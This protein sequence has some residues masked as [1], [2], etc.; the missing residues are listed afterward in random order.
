MSLLSLILSP[1]NRLFI[2]AA[3]DTSIFLCP[4]NALAFCFDFRVW[5]KIVLNFFLSILESYAKFPPQISASLKTSNFDRC[6]A[7]NRINTIH[8]LT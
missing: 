8:L 1:K 4:Y 2:N 3:P 5:L 6:P 7:L